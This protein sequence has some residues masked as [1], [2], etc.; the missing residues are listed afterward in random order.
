[1]KDFSNFH[2]LD[3]E[4]NEVK[5]TINDKWGRIENLSQELYRIAS[6]VKQPEYNP[7]SDLSIIREKY[8][9][10]GANSNFDDLYDEISAIVDN[11]VLSENKDQLF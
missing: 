9:E 2:L 5:N 11:E 10:T 6:K 4:T 8:E 1:M 7:N 3:N